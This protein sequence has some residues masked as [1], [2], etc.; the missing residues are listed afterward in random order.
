VELDISTQALKGLFSLTTLAGQK[1]KR[2]TVFFPQRLLAW[3]LQKNSN[4]A[5]RQKPGSSV[6][7]RCQR[8]DEEKL[9][10]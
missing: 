10:T 6:S 5:Q 7:A 2:I 3:S 8:F 1:D 4:K 9:R